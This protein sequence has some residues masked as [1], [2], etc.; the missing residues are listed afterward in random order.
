[1]ASSSKDAL[2]LPLMIDDALGQLNRDLNRLE[3]LLEQAD[4]VKQNGTIQTSCTNRKL[5]KSLLCR[6]EAQS[7]SFLKSNET[8]PR[9]VQAAKMAHWARL[10]FDK[11]PCNTGRVIKPLDAFRNNIQIFLHIIGLWNFAMKTLDRCLAVELVEIAQEMLQWRLKDIERYGEGD[12]GVKL[13]WN[14]FEDNVSI[15]FRALE[16]DPY[17]GAK[18]C[19]EM[20]SKNE[21]DDEYQLPEWFGQD[22]YEEQ[23]EQYI[24]ELEKVAADLQGSL[25]TTEDNNRCEKIESRASQGSSCSSTSTLIGG[26]SC[27]KECQLIGLPPLVREEHVPSEDMLTKAELSWRQWEIEI[28]QDLKNLT[29][30]IAKH[31]EEY[32]TTLRYDDRLDHHVFEYASVI[33]AL[34]KGK[35]ERCQPRYGNE[36]LTKAFDTLA[37]RLYLVLKRYYLYLFWLISRGFDYEVNCEVLEIVRELVFWGEQNGLVKSK[38]EAMLINSDTQPSP[39]NIEQPSDAEEVD[40]ANICPSEGSLN[41]SQETAVDTTKEAR[42][43]KQI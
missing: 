9:V 3:Y 6:V 29:Y 25:T 2:Q 7:A 12:E 41:D 16:K 1:M 31:T 42:G 4:E 32:G 11:A 36:D 24:W 19:T 17:F 22:G 37:G 39:H 26:C 28:D 8:D 18:A 43:M 40:T 38:V 35:A 10:W 20:E 33:A 15:M 13:Q 34:G 23:T 21:G 14:D 27:G 30:L 5:A